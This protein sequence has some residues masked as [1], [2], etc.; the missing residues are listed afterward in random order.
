MKNL[1]TLYTRRIS[2][3]AALF[4]KHLKG[5]IDGNYTRN[6]TKCTCPAILTSNLTSNITFSKIDYCKQND[7][8]KRFYSTN[9]GPPSTKLPPLMNFPEIMWPSFIKSIRNFIL[10]TFIIKPY[11]DKDFSLPDF[12]RGSKQALEVL[13]SYYINIPLNNLM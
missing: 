3:N 12:V 7:T 9:S 2:T 5:R 13:Y 10:S 8:K 11:F 1:I 4:A 6:Y